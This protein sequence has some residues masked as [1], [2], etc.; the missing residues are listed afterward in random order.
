MPKRM[1][2]S[3]F[4]MRAQS[5]H[6]NKYDYAQVQFVN[7]RSF[8]DIICPV[9]G[10]FSQRAF[11]HLQGN[12]CPECAKIWSD[13]HRENLQK[14]SRKSRGMTTE[15]WI[16]RAKSVHGDKYDYS[17]TVYVNQRTN[18]KIICPVHGLFEQKAD[19][20]IRGCGCRLCGLKSENHFGVHDWT[21]EQREKIKATCLQKYGV[22]RYLDSLEGKAKIKA[23]KSAPEFRQKMHDIIS[24]EDVQSKIKATCVEKYGANSPMKLFEIQSKVFATKFENKTF[25]TSK[26]EDTMYDILCDI[27]GNENVIRQYKS[28]EYPFACDFY[29]KSKNLYI[30]LNASWT[31]GY[32]WYNE[33]FDINTLSEW[34]DKAVDSHY[35]ENAIEVWTNRDVEKRHIARQHNLNY[36]VF[37][38]M[39]LSD[40]EMWI[41]HDCP[42]AKDW[43]REYSWMDI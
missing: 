20:H 29:I 4:I 10:V 28:D 27:F 26:T 1:T 14:S 17:Q 24:S 22:E 2:Q 33:K 35:Y 16:A 21:D 40:F 11:S 32:H 41:Q 5:I 18:V 36:V 15:E 23:T 42:D 19:S 43:Q 7:T 38:K 12:G 39:D 31:H 3:E 9:H 37:W 13:S 34:Q 8:V 6:D 30:E 25:N